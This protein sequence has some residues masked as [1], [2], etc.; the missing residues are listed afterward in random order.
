MDEEHDKPIF[1]VSPCGGKRCKICKQLIAANQ[2]RFNCGFTYVVQN[3]NLSCRSQNVVYVI[4]CITCNAE[5]IGETGN[6]RQR[7]NGH[8]SQ[9]RGNYFNACRT[10]EHFNSCGTH[11]SNVADRYNVFLLETVKDKAIRKAKESFF[12]NLFQPTINS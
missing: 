2:F 3:E 10:A 8:N 4:K 12:I 5:Y 1:K 9:I 11:L 7:I 6:F